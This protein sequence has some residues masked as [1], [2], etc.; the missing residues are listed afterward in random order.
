MFLV[1]DDGCS[2]YT[3]LNETDRAQANG[4]PNNS[5]RC[6][7]YYLTPG[8]YRFQEAAGDRM[9]DKCVPK[10]RCGTKAPGWLSCAHPTVAEGV[11]T[12]KVCYHWANDCC[13]DSN[14][15]KVKNCSSYFVYKLKATPRCYS[16]YCGNAGSG[17]LP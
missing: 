15:V 11:V 6:G 7:D 13:Y 16:R 9:L 17:K 5:P 2:I 8:W 3:V 1:E 10:Y 4:E 14:Y 12:R